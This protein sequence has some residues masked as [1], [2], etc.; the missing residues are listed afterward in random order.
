M[1]RSDRLFDIIQTLRA[2]SQ[3][4][5][6]MALAERL[7]VTPRTIYRDIAAL[8]ASRVPIEGA[9]GLGYV[10]RRGFDL[11]PLMFSLE[12]TDAIV[13]GVRLLCRLRDPTL[14]TATQNVRDKLAT[15]VPR[16]LQPQLVPARLFESEGRAPAVNGIAQSQLRNAI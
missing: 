3:P 6:A 8:Q 9:P 1:R 10:L 4:L 15:V 13:I 7:E 12:E 11:P 5:T 14:Q 16:E 2:A